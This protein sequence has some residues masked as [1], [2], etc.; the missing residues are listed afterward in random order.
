MSQKNKLRVLV[1]TTFNP[2]FNLATEDWIFKELDPSTK[3]L[4]LWRNEPTVVIGRFQNPWVECQT[5]KMAQDGVHLARRQSGGGTV[6]QDLGNTNF[7]FL[8][9]KES[10]SK[11]ANNE[12]VTKAIAK[13]G[14]HCYPSGR[15]DIVVECEKGVRKISGS[16][17]KEKIDRSFH[18][19]TLLIDANL[20]RLGNY[21]SPN[22]KKL[23]AK[24]VTSVRSRVAN[25]TEYNPEINHDLLSSEI[26]K[27]FFNYYQSEC[28]IEQLD[29]N[30]L[31]SIP[32][33]RTY[34]EFL[35]DEKWRYG[36]TPDFSHHL[37]ERFDW[38]SVDI[39]FEVQKGLIK[40]CVIFTDSLHPEM[41][42]ELTKLFI[43]SNYSQVG[44]K[45]VMS[46]ALEEFSFL[47]EELQELSNWLQDQ[48]S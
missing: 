37:Y 47:K 10:F 38:A 13:F 8:S 29:H 23:T 43:G 19:G 2:F 14:I 4:F 44:V 18:H 6:F 41:I 46:K 36:E 5:K 45:S 11:K 3:V 9:S 48:V 1:S 42:E 33:L 30:Y 28:L 16:A 35:E 34:Y 24:G 22:E 31:K 17:F 12:I 7:T 40:D 27:Q 15:N 26:I 25:L 39:H 21:L 20:K 32:S